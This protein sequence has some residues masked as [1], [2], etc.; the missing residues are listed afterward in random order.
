[1]NIAKIKTGTRDDTTIG[2]EKSEVFLTYCSFNCSIFKHF[3][4]IAAPRHVMKSLT[5]SLEWKKKEVEAFKVLKAE[6]SSSLVLT[7]P[8]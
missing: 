8:V 4:K 1:M 6:M 2:K 3:A 5:K 7:F